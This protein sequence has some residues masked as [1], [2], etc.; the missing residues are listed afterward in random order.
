[1]P[2]GNVMGERVQLVADVWGSMETHLQWDR[3]RKKKTKAT[4]QPFFHHANLVFEF[5]QNEHILPI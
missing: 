2:G 5:I 3:P 1:M 4:F